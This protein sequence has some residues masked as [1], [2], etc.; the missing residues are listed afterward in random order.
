[1]R[2]ESVPYFVGGSNSGAGK[3]VTDGRELKRSKHK[4]RGRNV[5]RGREC[6]GDDSGEHIVVNEGGQ[7]EDRPRM[8]SVVCN[9]KR[10]GSRRSRPG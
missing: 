9:M 5:S 10:E 1:M 2:K 4:S 8:R 6:Q 7:E 3:R